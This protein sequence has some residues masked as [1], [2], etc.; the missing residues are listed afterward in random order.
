MKLKKATP[1]IFV[2]NIDA[3]INFYEKLGFSLTNSVTSPEGALVWAQMDL[4]EVTFMFQTYASIDNQWPMVSR[5]DGGSL[6]LYIDVTGIRDYYS[7]IKT[8]VTP[9]TGLE[10]TFYG[11]TEFSVCDNNNYLL[12]FAEHE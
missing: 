4:G 10:K 12:T 2:K 1:N 3:T 11:A 5:T 9:L 8:R 7:K 6:L